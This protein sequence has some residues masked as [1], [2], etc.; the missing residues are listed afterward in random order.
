[1]EE[2]AW[3]REGGARPLHSMG[4]VRLVDGIELG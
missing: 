1:M 3:W 4:G 2:R